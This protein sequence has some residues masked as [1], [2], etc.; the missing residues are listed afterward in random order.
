MGGFTNVNM[1]N[2]AASPRADSSQASLRP[3]PPGLI[4]LTMEAIYLPCYRR[5]DIFF[6]FKVVAMDKMIC[7]NAAGFKDGQ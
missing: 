1:P 4:P 2:R 7:Q 5:G 6:F 3:L